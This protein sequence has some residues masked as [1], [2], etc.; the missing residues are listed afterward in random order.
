MTTVAII[1]VDGC[2]KTTQAKLLVEKLNKEGFKSIYVQPTYIL[3]KFFTT[4]KKIPISPREIGTSKI[5]K[6]TL[7]KL[8]IC[9]IGYL[10]A[11]FTYFIIKLWS[12]RSIV[13]CDRYFYQFFYDL[14]GI[15]S[16]NILKIFPK[17]DITFFLDGEVDIF[18]TRMDKFDKSTYKTYYETI[19]KFYRQ[20]AEKYG[21]ITINTDLKKEEINE[22]MLRYM[23]EA[24]L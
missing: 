7:D 16:E 12:I 21:F 1:G 8:L 9:L 14:C 19:I 3:F 2:G 17:T 4:K 5:K 10:Y 6:S 23:E 22:I 15:Q 20:L 11:L 24:I 13:I 18:Y